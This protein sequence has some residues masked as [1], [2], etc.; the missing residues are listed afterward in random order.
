MPA[1]ITDRDANIE[2]VALRWDEGSETW[3]LLAVG[4]LDEC[5]EACRRCR[6]KGNKTE[7]VVYVTDEI[8]GPE[9]F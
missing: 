4:S 5:R 6:A 3:S 7:L 9:T 1:S 2:A 8:A